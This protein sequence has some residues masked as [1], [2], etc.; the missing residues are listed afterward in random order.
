[1]IVHSNS[2]IRYGKKKYYNYTLKQISLTH[3]TR[4]LLIRLTSHKVLR[5]QCKYERQV[6]Q[7]N[8]MTRKDDRAKQ[9]THTHSML[10]KNYL[11]TT[12]TK[13]TGVVFS[14]CAAR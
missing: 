14:I 11:Q 4:L 10:L 2:V 9:N 8:K 5:A 7:G 13:I 1:M 12:E 3:S 6:P